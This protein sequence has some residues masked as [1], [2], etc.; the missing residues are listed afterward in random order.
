MRVGYPVADT[1][2]GMTAAFAISRALVRRD[3]TGEGAFIDVSMLDSALGDDGM[4][5][6]ELPD[7][8]VRR[9]VP[10]G[11]DNFT[12]AP[13][14]AFTTR[15]GLSTSP[16]TS[17]SSSR[18]SRWRRPRGSGHRSALRR[19]RSRKRNRAALTRRWKRRL[20]RRPRPNGSDSQSHRHSGRPRA[21][22]P[23]GAG[24]AAGAARE[25]LQ[26]FDDVPGVDR[27]ITVTRTGFKLS[28][29]NPNGESPPPRLGEHTD[30]FWTAADT[31]RPNRRLRNARAI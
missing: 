18:R 5:R 13:S 12:A 6:L 22:R 11:N 29:G 8:R 1:L 25:L 20:R 31:A 19:A 3:E 15:D 21:H 28:G 14:G 24:A 23:R 10:M 2:G 7:R 4:G 16:R 26:T 9:R 27:P 30:E 17:R